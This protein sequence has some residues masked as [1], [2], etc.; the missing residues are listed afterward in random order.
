MNAL[1]ATMNYFIP[2]VEI[3]LRGV[4]LVAFGGLIETFYKIWQNQ[5]LKDDEHICA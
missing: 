4:L 3:I 2:T 5:E 1:I